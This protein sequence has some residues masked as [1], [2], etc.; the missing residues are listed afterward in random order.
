MNHEKTTKSS[1]A[2]P[3]ETPESTPA[4][5]RQ[6]KK[7]RLL[8]RDVKPAEPAVS[9]PPP[10]PDDA[11]SEP[12][13]SASSSGSATD[14]HS[15]ADRPGLATRTDNPLSTQTQI[16]RSTLTEPYESTIL[17]DLKPPPPPRKQGVPH[18]LGAFFFVLAVALTAMI[19]LVELGY[20]PIL[21]PVWKGVAMYASLLLG[22][23]VLVIYRPVLS[24]AAASL[25][26]VFFTAA[27]LDIIAPWVFTAPFFLPMKN[28]LP[29]AA[30][31]ASVTMFAI[32][33]AAP[34]RGFSRKRHAVS[35][36]CGCA[37]MTL[38]AAHGLTVIEN[39]TGSYGYSRHRKPVQFELVTAST[40]DYTLALPKAWQTLPPDKS[41]DELLRARSPDGKVN[42]RLTRQPV[43]SRPDLTKWAARILANHARNQAGASGMVLEQPGNAAAKK[44]VL[45]HK[46]HV[47]ESVVQAT[48]TALFM[49][50]VTGT[51]PDVRRQRNRLDNV[52]QSFTLLQPSSTT[53]RDPASFT[54]SETSGGKAL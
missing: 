50:S 42:L 26:V 5:E 36:L 39:W 37:G 35:L 45:L 23:L 44:V 17:R 16:R 30:V 4:T 40:T 7:L 29:R 33:A 49:L 47:T 8:H 51:R 27:V 28:L 14:D 31:S 13:P 12:A 15:K 32:A 24:T 9:T 1:E 48:D 54:M 43:S 10:I 6:G 46:G 3:Q 11:K 52:Y 41:Q 38:F 20:P 19:V 53:Q 2:V 21:H 18:A 25:A 34:F 22:T